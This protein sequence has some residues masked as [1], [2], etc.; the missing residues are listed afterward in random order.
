MACVA[1][2]IIVVALWFT[3]FNEDD[4][5]KAAAAPT[6]PVKVYP[7]RGAT[8]DMVKTN[9]SVACDTAKVA[10]VVLADDEG[11]VSHNGTLITSQWD[12]DSVLITFEGDAPFT[13]GYVVGAR[14]TEPF[15]IPG[16][17]QGKN[18]PGLALDTTD[19]S[20]SGQF[21]DIYLCGGGM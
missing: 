1:V 4:Q 16:V 8:P 17:A 5:P 2:I 20:K 9:K 11:T 15:L 10:S 6:E 14:S 13:S 19:F 3:F 12:E 18:S 7:E 21:L